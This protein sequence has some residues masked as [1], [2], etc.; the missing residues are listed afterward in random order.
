[1]NYLFKYTSRIGET[2]KNAVDSRNTNHET[3]QNNNSF[4]YLSGSPQSIE[5][6]V[7]AQQPFQQ[8]NYEHCNTHTPYQIPI[9]PPSPNQVVHSNH[10]NQKTNQHSQQY[11]NLSGYNQCDVP[12]N[13]HMDDQPIEQ[14]NNLNVL[15]DAIE[16][17]Q[18]YEYQA[19]QIQSPITYDSQL[20]EEEEK[21]EY[22][23][24][25][26]LKYCSSAIESNETKT[27]NKEQENTMFMHSNRYP[28]NHPMHKIDRSVIPIR[29]METETVEKKDIVPK[30]SKKS[31]NEFYQ[32]R[33]GTDIRKK[34]NQNLGLFME[35]GKRRSRRNQGKTKHIG[36]IQTIHRRSNRVRKRI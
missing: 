15:N 22:E 26:V 33:I 27:E 36:I 23:S 21:N 32:H 13:K 20:T 12:V 4:Q 35:N 6:V 2:I 34:T 7:H 19:S 9:N 3:E 16:S 31:K 18:T 8:S 11:V 14:K 30:K 28:E 1:M 24:D 25:P 17:K 10:S 29:K 5:Q